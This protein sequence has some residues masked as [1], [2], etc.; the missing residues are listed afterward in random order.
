MLVDCRYE[1][2]TKLRIK[3][4]DQACQGVSRPPHS[5]NEAEAKVWVHGFVRLPAAFQQPQ[6]PSALRRITTNGSGRRNLGGAVAFA[7]YSKIAPHCIGL[8]PDKAGITIH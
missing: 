6:L 3:L 2:D 4:R 7:R 1:G 5:A 8:V